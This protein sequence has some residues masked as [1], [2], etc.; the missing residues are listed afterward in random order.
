MSE[1]PLA[2]PSVVV[3]ISTYNG[4][5]FLREL[6]K[7]VFD[8]DYGN[9]RILVRDDG[10]SDSTKNILS[11]FANRPNVDIIY[12]PNLGV[13]RSFF[14]LIK[15]AAVEF[16]YVALCDQDDVWY[17]NKISR[18][19]SALHRPATVGEPAMYC[20]GYTL[21]DETLAIIGNSKVLRRK[22]SLANALVENIATGCTVV[23]NRMAASLILGRKPQHCLMHDWWLY[24][25]VS[26]LGTIIYDPTPS[27]MY[28]QHSTNVVGVARG[29]LPR[30]RNRVDSLIRRRFEPVIWRQVTEFESLYGGVL[31][32][33]ERQLVKAFLKCHD[34]VR[35]RVTYA[36]RG[37]VHRQTR[38]DDL[39]LR[40]FLMLGWV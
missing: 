6:L 19:V 34:S 12:G 23:L 38:T 40:I 27:L 9:L 35:T 17:P 18:A 25:I 13:I 26:A 30:L 36:I 8:Q 7:S 28:R 39:I 4:E 5:R 14:S 22:P 16:D 24:L 21:V 20:S 29:W 2:L 15:M 10:S 1:V 32:E 3:V 33:N 11:S 31:G 37:K